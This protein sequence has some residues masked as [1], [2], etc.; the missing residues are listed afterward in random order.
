MK[1]FFTVSV[2]VLIILTAVLMSQQ[3]TATMTAEPT[4]EAGENLDLQAVLELLEDAENLEEFEKALNDSSNEVNNL[5]L[6]EDGQ[7]DYIRVVELSEENTHVIVLQVALGENEYQDV[8]TVEIEKSGEEDVSVQAV[9]DEEIYG[10]G[11]I[12]EPETE[13][14]ESS[15]TI[16]VVHTWPV[17]RL[18]FR[19]GYPLWVSPWRWRAY[20]VWWHPW[21]PFARSTYHARVVKRHRHVYRHTKV[22]KSRRGASIYGP[23]RKTSPKATH[24]KKKNVQKQQKKK[25]TTQK[26]TT[27]QKKKTT[28]QKKETAPKKKKP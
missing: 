26:K 4:T 1:S 20:P 8:A 6:D 28:T 9:G 14:K 21:R 25:H 7:V 19:P 12:I 23:K 24:K 3:E 18:I 16:V 22:R 5:D 17:V 27:Q 11:Y 2:I 13:S 10:E 15:T